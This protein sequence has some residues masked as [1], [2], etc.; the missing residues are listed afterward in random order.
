MK[1]KYIG[2]V[3][4]GFYVI[5]GYSKKSNSGKYNSYFLVRCEKCG[6]E[7]EKA[8]NNLF[9]GE[10]TCMCSYKVRLHN[11][12]GKS[13]TRLNRIYRSMLD[14]CFNPKSRPYKYYGGRGITICNEWVEDFSLFYKWAI[15]NGYKENLTIDRID[16]NGNY[17]P[18]NC[19]WVTMEVQNKNKR[20]YG[21][22]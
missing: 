4:N 16:N 12:D 19:R 5:K 3:I 7:Q 13:N 18:D 22:G 21:K 9:K 14:R 1:S 10:A 6:K 15:Q 17:A 8:R 20:P 2:K 11:A